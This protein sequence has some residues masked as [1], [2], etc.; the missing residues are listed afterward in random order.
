MSEKGRPDPDAL[1]ARIQ[2]EQRESHES[3]RGQLRIYLGAFPGVGK[4]YAMLNEARRRR[5]YG[6]EVVVGFAETHGRRGTQEQ[7]EG[8]ELLPRKR[9]DYQGVI[10]EELDVDAVLRRRPAVCLV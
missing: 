10:V 9:I 1:L 7:L 3:G 2:R 6:E 4:T 5:R 8:L